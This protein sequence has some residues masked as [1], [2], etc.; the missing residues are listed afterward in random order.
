M[1]DDKL[2]ARSLRVFLPHG[3]PEARAGVTLIM[4]TN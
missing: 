1:M 2:R 3:N 4:P